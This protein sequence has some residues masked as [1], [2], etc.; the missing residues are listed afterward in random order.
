MSDVD[1]T[2]PPPAARADPPDE[3]P[4]SDFEADLDDDSSDDDEAEVDNTPPRALIG[5]S[6]L[7]VN[8]PQRFKALPPL[9]P[10]RVT[11]QRGRVAGTHSVWRR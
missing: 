7:P 3:A 2:P 9:D 1:V 5:N 11:T 10:D 6:A 4:E 8:L